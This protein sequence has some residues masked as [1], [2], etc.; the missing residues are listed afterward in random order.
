MCQE[1]GDGHASS[2]QSVKAICQGISIRLRQVVSYPPGR[3][4]HIICVETPIHSLHTCHFFVRPANYFRVPAFWPSRPSVKVFAVAT[5]V[6]VGGVPSPDTFAQERYAVQFVSHREIPWMPRRTMETRTSSEL[7]K[8]AA[9]LQVIKST[10]QAVQWQ[11]W[12]SSRAS[13]FFCDC[14]K[15]PTW[16]RTVC[17]VVFV[18]VRC[19]AGEIRSR[20]HLHVHYAKIEY[21]SLTLHDLIP[22]A[23]V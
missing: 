22:R 13:I 10:Y 23:R 6:K 8:A 15:I 7:P 20:P 4:K 3:K 9:Q 21:T 1:S 11:P 14:D 2:G 16:L 19:S 17:Y 5:S 12:N 18:G